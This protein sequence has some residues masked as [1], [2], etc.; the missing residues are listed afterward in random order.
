MAP[1][2]LLLVALGNVNCGAAAPDASATG[3]VPGESRSC[4]CT[5]GHSGAQV[6]QHDA[7]FGACA[8]GSEV[9]PDIGAS[10]ERTGNDLANASD[11]GPSAPPS[12]MESG[13]TGIVQTICDE[14]FVALDKK[15]DSCCASPTDR[16]HFESL[17]RARRAKGLAAECADVLQA[18]SSKHRIEINAEAAAKCVQVSRMKL[19]SL[20]CGDGQLRELTSV[21]DPDTCSNVVVGLLSSDQPCARSFE[22]GPNLS[23]IGQGPDHE[24]VCRAIPTGLGVCGPTAGPKSI[25]RFPF[26]PPDCG[27]DLICGRMDNKDPFTC[28]VGT[29][30]SAHAVGPALRCLIDRDC[31]YGFF[32]PSRSETDIPVAQHGYCF[33]RRAAGAPCSSSNGCRGYCS[34]AIDGPCAEGLGPIRW[35]VV[36]P[37]RRLAARTEVCPFSVISCEEEH[38]GAGTLACNFHPGGEWMLRL[39]GVIGH[40]RRRR[41]IDRNRTFGLRC[42]A[43]SPV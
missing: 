23:C 6:C 10:V 28:G 26:E 18:S 22:C 25:T 24:G 40:L 34:D 17:R 30:T 27:D 11:A 4:A 31:A 9:P 14:I 16:S 13:S 37:V 29:R 33:P 7:T 19:D 1:L 8:C 15:L 41:H 39:V 2:F 36:S 32:C 20:A 43:R 42:A 5:S 38:D 3:C 35:E 12:S 21:W